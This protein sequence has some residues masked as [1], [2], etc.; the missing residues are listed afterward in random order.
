MARKQVPIPQYPCSHNDDALHCPTCTQ[1]RAMR[2]RE[3]HRD[4]VPAQRT[5]PVQRVQAGHEAQGFPAATLAEYL[6]Y[7]SEF[8]KSTRGEPHDADV[9]ARGT[10][11]H[12]YWLRANF[13][14]SHL[15]PLGL[16]W[17]KGS[18]AVVPIEQWGEYLRRAH[19]CDNPL[20]PHSPATGAHRGRDAMQTALRQMGVHAMAKGI[21]L[22]FGDTC[23]HCH[24]TK[25]PVPR[26]AGDSSACD[27]RV[28]KPRPRAR[29]TT[30]PATFAAVAQ[31]AEEAQLVTP[32]AV[33]DPII[34]EF[35]GYTQADWDKLFKPDNFIQPLDYPVQP[36]GCPVPA[37]SQ[38]GWGDY[39]GPGQP[40]LDPAPPPG[41]SPD[42]D[43]VSYAIW[44]PANN[45]IKE[46]SP[47]L[48]PG[49]IPCEGYE[50]APN[51]GL[52]FQNLYNTLTNELRAN[53]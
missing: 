26:R 50:N 3:I 40:F 51:D 19:I 20:D 31:L 37:Q 23:P 10:A 8:D 42:I 2:A 15:S 5:G 1:A 34:E 21:L 35:K 17:K 13:A 27:N 33:P 49:L 53:P 14:L 39:P 7:L 46:P 48:D 4:N 25:K 22:A 11:Q 18:L 47:G 44:G 12:R 41:V 16:S 38:A 52:F 43:S 28:S 30:A 36:Q 6:T 45:P 29:R 24:V 9:L 32:A